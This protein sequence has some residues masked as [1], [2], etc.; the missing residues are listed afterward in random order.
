MIDK[1]GKADA[2]KQFNDHFL[3][4]IQVIKVS[5]INESFLFLIL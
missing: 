3:P 4:I 5:I 1:I 2:E